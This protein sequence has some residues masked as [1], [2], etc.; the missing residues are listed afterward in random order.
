MMRKSSGEEGRPI[1][2]E[3]CRLAAATASSEGRGE[4][5]IPS[6]SQIRLTMG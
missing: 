5:Q 4:S 6:C 3:A 2:A 1:W